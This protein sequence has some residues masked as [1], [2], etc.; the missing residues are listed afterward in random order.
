MRVHRVPEVTLRKQVSENKRVQGAS[1]F[2][3]DDPP[4]SNHESVLL[5]EP[6]HIVPPNDEQLL[7][8]SIAASAAIHV[9]VALVA[10][11]VLL[12]ATAHWEL[13]L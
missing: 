2:L 4:L 3:S 11:S 13:T 8:K 5:D 12:I 10:T 9:R 1:A 6:E 7:Q